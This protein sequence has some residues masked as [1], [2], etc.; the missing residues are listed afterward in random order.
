M[1]RGRGCSSEITR[2]CSAG[3]LS[4]CRKTSTGAGLRLVSVVLVC[5]RITA[6]LKQFGSL[7]QFSGQVRSQRLTCSKALSAASAV[8]RWAFFGSDIASNVRRVS[9]DSSGNALKR[10]M[11]LLIGF[12]ERPKIVQFLPVS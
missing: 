3:F 8:N 4:P 12:D 1:T 9:S 11:L 5:E 6:V 2:A 7:I 10:E